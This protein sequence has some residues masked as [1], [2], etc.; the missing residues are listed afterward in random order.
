LYHSRIKGCDRTP[1]C[2]KRFN[3]SDLGKIKKHLGIWYDWREEAN[4]DHCK[5]MPKLVKEIIESFESHMEREVRDRLYQ[6]LRCNFH[7][8]KEED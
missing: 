1:R 7:K 6:E 5:S 2:E 8:A 3:I 4:G